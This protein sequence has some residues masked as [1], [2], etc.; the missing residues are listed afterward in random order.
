M[1]FQKEARYGTCTQMFKCLHT[2]TY[3]HPQTHMQTRTHKAKKWSRL[4]EARE[5]RRDEL[6]EGKKRSFPLH[7]ILICC[8][9]IHSQVCPWPDGPQHAHTWTH[10]HAHTF[11]HM[12]G[13]EPKFS[14]ESIVKCRKFTE[15]LNVPYYFYANSGNRKERKY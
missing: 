14:K 15:P 7:L 10:V 5:T 6:N 12:D 13:Q 11:M 9:C 4:N 8:D 1:T 2:H 3:T